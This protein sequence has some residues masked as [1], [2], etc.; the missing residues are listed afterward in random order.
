LAAPSD[1]ISRATL[2]ALLA[3]MFDTCLLGFVW[4]VVVAG[5]GV[6][7]IVS[8]LINFRRCCALRL[9]GNSRVGIIPI[10]VSS[11]GRM[12]P[13]WCLVVPFFHDCLRL[14]VLANM[15]PVYLV[16]LLL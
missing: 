7:K 11:E 8:G 16:G 9:K 15:H 13:C 12:T 6:T 14:F 1:R 10:C 5:A 3:D 4:G 2:L